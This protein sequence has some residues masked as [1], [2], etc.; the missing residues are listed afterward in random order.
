[1]KG[2]SDTGFGFRTK[3]NTAGQEHPRSLGIELHTSTNK[4]LIK[5]F[6]LVSGWDSED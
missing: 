6:Y 1:M 3:A 5:N 2:P 4:F